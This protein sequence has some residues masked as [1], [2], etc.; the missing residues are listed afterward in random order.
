MSF[1]L[2]VMPVDRALTAEEASAEV[3]RLARSSGLAFGHDKRLDPFIEAMESR[4]QRLRGRGPTP[5][6]FEFDVRR[7]HVAIGIPWPRV[8][9]VATAVAD[10]AWRSGLA[11]YDP[12]RE[13]VGLPAPYA[14]G[15]LTSD[16][17]EAHVRRAEEALS[18]I[19][20][21]DLE[22]SD[23]EVS[24][25]ETFD[26]ETLDEETLDDGT[27]DEEPAT[28][29]SSVSG[30]LAGMGFRQYSPLGFEVTPELE[31]EAMADPLRMPTSLQTSDRKAQ[32]IEDLG[33]QTSGE[34]HRALVQLAGWDPDPE[35]AVALRP[36]LVSDDVFAASQA[37]AGLGRQGDITDLPAVLDLVR[38]LSPADGASTETMVIPL[39]AALDLAALAGPDIVKG[40]RSRAR[41][42]RGARPVR[43][44][45]WENELDRELDE[46]LEPG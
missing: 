45:S 8:E 27:L 16:G 21:G 11:V 32:L 24:D 15:P 46:L 29:G 2:F 22:V 17:V 1:D 36:L 18:E 5:P 20:Q 40:V 26:E 9:E 39:R 13:A 42:W 41:T 4:Y 14:D 28:V 37:A 25:D 44:Q 10:A 12:Q 3:D 38:R 6:P 33:A 31:D 23:D 19:E 30:R 35:V 7:S 43:R 34:R